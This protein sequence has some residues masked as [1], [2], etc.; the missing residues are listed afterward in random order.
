MV[1]WRLF[2]LEM[3]LLNT[4]LLEKIQ[5]LELVDKLEIRSR[6]EKDLLT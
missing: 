1:F 6:H 3:D 4:F 5:V 2:H